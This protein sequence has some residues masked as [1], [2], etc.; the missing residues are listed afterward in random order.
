MSTPLH[1]SSRSP[2]Q[3]RSVDGEGI[4]GSRRAG[5]PGA[6]VIQRRAIPASARDPLCSLARRRQGQAA[7]P[8]FAP[9]VVGLVAAR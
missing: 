8:G 3:A 9:A 1:R 7:W 6:G 5:V 4:G 2:T